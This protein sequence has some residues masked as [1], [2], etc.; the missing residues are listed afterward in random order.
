MSVRNLKKEA[1]EAIKVIYATLESDQAETVLDSNIATLAGIIDAYKGSSAIKKVRWRDITSSLDDGIDEEILLLLLREKIDLFTPDFRSILRET[2][3]DSKEQKDT[4]EP[5]VLNTGPKMSHMKWTKGNLVEWIRFVS[6]FECM[7]EEYTYTKEK[8]LNRFLIYTMNSTEYSMIEMLSKSMSDWETIAN[9]ITV[10]KTNTLKG[11]RQ[12]RLDTITQ[13]WRTLEEYYFEF[14]ENRVIQEKIQDVVYTERE[15]VDAFQKGLWK[16]FRLQLLN[17]ITDES[18]LIKYFR[19]LQPLEVK[20]RMLTEMFIPE[21]PW[22][23]QEHSEKKK[24]KS[25]STRKVPDKEKMCWFKGKCNR[26]ETCKFKHPKEDSED[27]KDPKDDVTK[28]KGK[29]KK[30]VSQNFVCVKTNASAL[31]ENLVIWDSGSNAMI[32]NNLDDFETYNEFKEPDVTIVGGGLKVKLLG[33]GIVNWTS[34]SS[35][36]ESL[37]IE[38]YYAPDFEMT[39]ISQSKLDKK[40]VEQICSN[41]K[42]S[43]RLQ[44]SLLMTGKLTNEELYTLDITPRKPDEIDVALNQ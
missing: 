10:V 30:Q 29:K 34:D 4:Q 26:K 32:H 33:K 2:T 3:G 36:F 44:D 16:D 1:L 21:S 38:M 40:G 43:F 27:L 17:A 18:S 25:N 5:F 20:Y 28:T 24:K 39:I 9:E 6:H 14:E 42:L 41:G 7:V 11:D 19:S 15:K 13:G 37:P 23:D 22:D 12:E 31:K 35:E 8:A